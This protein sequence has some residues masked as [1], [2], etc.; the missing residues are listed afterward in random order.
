[1]N[2]KRVKELWIALSILVGIALV[3]SVVA[4]LGG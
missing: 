1:M 2:K 3:F 4:L